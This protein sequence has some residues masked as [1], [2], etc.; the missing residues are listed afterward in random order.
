MNVG[1]IYT[2]NLNGD[3]EILELINSKHTR[4]RFLDTNTVTKAHPDCIKKGVVKDHNRPSV[5][6]VGFAG[7]AGSISKYGKSVSVWRDILKRC[8]CPRW[9][10]VIQTAPSPL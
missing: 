3:V 9:Q 7:M 5:Y 4:V 8:Y 1:D 10:N 6:G 2:T